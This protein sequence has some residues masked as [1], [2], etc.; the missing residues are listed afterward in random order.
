MPTHVHQHHHHPGAG[1]P[2]ASI[3]PSILRASVLERLGAAGVVIAL[4]WASVLWAMA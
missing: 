2:P 3:S 4:I 1:H